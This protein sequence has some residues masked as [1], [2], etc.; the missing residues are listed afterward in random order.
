M[1]KNSGLEKRESETAELKQEKSYKCPA[2]LN[3]SLLAH[4]KT[5]LLQTSEQIIQKQ[6]YLK[7]K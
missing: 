1:F 7:Y 4:L 5:T 3:T 6:L 2:C